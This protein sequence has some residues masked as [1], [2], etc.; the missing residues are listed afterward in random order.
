MS[1]YIQFYVKSKNN[2]FCPIGIYCRSSYIYQT[3]IRCT[4]V[5]WEAITPINRAIINRAYDD[6]ELGIKEHELSL[7]S[8]NED[9]ELICKMAGITL[10]ERLDKIAMINEL[11]EEIKDDIAELERCRGF[12]RSLEDI[13]Y[14]V[15]YE[16]NYDINNYLYVGLEIDHPTIEDIK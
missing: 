4:D 14:T 16:D 13:L 7:K 10:E 5:P 2:D 6:I 12:L 11:N 9:K 15:E 3:F 1:A 8:S